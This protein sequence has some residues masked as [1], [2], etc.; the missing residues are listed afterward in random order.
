VWRE[1]WAGVAARYEQSPPPARL[2]DA[3]GRVPPEPVDQVER[4]RELAARTVADVLRRLA[5]G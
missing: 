3:D 4:N 2:I 1:R 5:A